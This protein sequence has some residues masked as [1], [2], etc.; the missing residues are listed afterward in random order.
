MRSIK[1]LF[2]VKIFTQTTHHVAHMGWLTLNLSLGYL[3]SMYAP[4]RAM[5]KSW[6]FFKS[7]LDKWKSLHK[8]E[9]PEPS[10]W[11][12]PMFRVPKLEGSKD[13][14]RPVIDLRAVNNAAEIDA[15]TIPLIEEILNRQGRKNMWAG[16]KGC[17]FTNSPCTR[18]SS[19]F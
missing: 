11:E 14:F 15:Y 19:Y 8:L 5:V 3:Q 1:T 2:F 6:S 7:A 4:Y 9:P 16:F 12:S 13:P 17:I 10:G 18:S